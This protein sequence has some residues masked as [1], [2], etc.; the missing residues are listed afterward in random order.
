M[1]SHRV[2][3]EFFASGRTT[4]RD[5]GPAW[6]KKEL[7]RDIG[8]AMIYEVARNLRRAICAPFLVALN[9]PA[10][11][12]DSRAGHAPDRLIRH[13]SPLL[14]SPSFTGSLIFSLS[15]LSLSLVGE[16]TR[17]HFLLVLFF[18]SREENSRRYININE[19]F[20]AE[21]KAAITTTPR[22]SLRDVFS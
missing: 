20:C 21:I 19:S 7:S 8:R 16:S 2:V 18:T 17:K 4:R 1:C 22:P 12:N 3:L 15:L 14:R 6:E 13:F 5:V 11:I 10:L 9:D